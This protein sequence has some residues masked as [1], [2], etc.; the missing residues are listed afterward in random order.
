MD[1]VNSNSKS[2][3]YTSLVRLIV[4]YASLCWDTYRE[5]QINAL[6]RVQNTSI[7]G[8]LQH[9]RNHLNWKTLAQCRKIAHVRALFT[10]YTRERAWKDL[11]DRLQKPCRAGSIMVGKLG[12][13]NERQMQENTPL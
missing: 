11:R 13:R 4:E 12:A 7:A 10:A 6:D 8:E 9:E 3:V 5:G 1:H 2:L